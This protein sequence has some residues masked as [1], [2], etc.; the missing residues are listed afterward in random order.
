MSK[1]EELVHG[2]GTTAGMGTPSSVERAHALFGGLRRSRAL[3]CQKDTRQ[4][5]LFC[6]HGRGNVRG[7]SY[8]H[9][10]CREIDAGS[11]SCIIKI[12]SATH[13]AIQSVYVPIMS[14][15]LCIASRSTFGGLAT[16]PIKVNIP[17]VLHLAC[18]VSWHGYNIA[19]QPSTR[20]CVES[21]CMHRICQNST[22]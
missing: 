7:L 9:H 19:D 4:Y 8:E 17:Q 21:P 14:S 3:H 5:N 2:P 11:V 13:T 20:E 22:R 15:C 18:E 6:A 16:I 10:P 12:P 1:S